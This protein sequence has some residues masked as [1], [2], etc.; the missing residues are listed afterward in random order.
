MRVETL[1]DRVIGKL[2]GKVEEALAA[3]LPH[4]A[5][6]WRRRIH[7]VN[8]PQH[9]LPSWLHDVMADPGWGVGIDRFQRIRY[10]GSYADPERYD[11]TVGW[12]S[13]A[14]TKPPPV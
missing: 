10:I 6:W 9:L 4:D 3:M 7:Y 12:F 14:S 1:E 11:S 2:Q 5:E 13:Q 8:V